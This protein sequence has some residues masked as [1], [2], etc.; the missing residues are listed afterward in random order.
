MQTTPRKGG[1]RLVNAQISSQAVRDDSQSR[2]RTRKPGERSARRREP[3]ARRKKPSASRKDACATP[4]SVLQA[5]ANSSPRLQLPL[6]T[7]EPLIASY[8][9]LAAPTNSSPRPRAALRTLRTRRCSYDVVAT[10]T[11][12]SLRSRT[13]IGHSRTVLAAPEGAVRLPNLPR[14]ACNGMRIQAKNS[15]GGR[16]NTSVTPHVREYRNTA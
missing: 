14:G 12:K 10:A 3:F 15:S 8:E 7:H 4:E 9:R 5:L 11:N 6:R 13:R 2:R 16:W 1:A